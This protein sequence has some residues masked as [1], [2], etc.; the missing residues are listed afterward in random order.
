MGCNSPPRT[1]VWAVIRVDGAI[2]GTDH[3][4]RITVKEIVRS[5]EIALAEVDRLNNLHA[6]LNC[7]Y[8]CQMSRLFS[9]G[10][11]F[12]TH[13]DDGGPVA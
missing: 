8:F 3:E 2:D 10:E 9:H 11:S 7:W 12:G 5:H 6:H 13:P 1:K 4:H